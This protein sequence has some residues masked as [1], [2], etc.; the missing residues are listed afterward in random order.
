MLLSFLDPLRL[1]V[2]FPD[3]LRRR[4][5]GDPDWEVALRGDGRRVLGSVRQQLLQLRVRDLV[6]LAIG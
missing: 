1:L 6:R 2:G 4:L 5:D 3:S